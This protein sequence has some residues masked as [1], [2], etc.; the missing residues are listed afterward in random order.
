[1]TW[2]DVA[3]TKAQTEKVEKIETKVFWAQKIPH[4]KK[5]HFSKTGGER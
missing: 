3:V 2:T 5:I 1:M 4:H